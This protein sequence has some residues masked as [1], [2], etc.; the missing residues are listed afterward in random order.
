MC[1]SDL[2]LKDGN[3]VDEFAKL[4]RGGA[5][6]DSFSKGAPADLEAWLSTKGNLRSTDDDGERWD[7]RCTGPNVKGHKCETLKKSTTVDLGATNAGLM[8][9]P[10]AF[11]VILNL[12]IPTGVTGRYAAASL[13]MADGMGV[14]RLLSETLLH[15]HAQVHAYCKGCSLP[16]PS[17]I[18][19]SEWT[20]GAAKPS[21]VA[22]AAQ[23]KVASDAAPVDPNDVVLNVRLAYAACGGENTDG[24]TPDELTDLFEASGVTIPASNTS[25]LFNA[26][27][28]D[29][30]GIL[31]ISEFAV[32]YSDKVQVTAILAYSANE[33]DTSFDSKT[34]LEAGISQIGRAS[35]RERV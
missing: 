14:V 24:V 32:L 33:I 3:A 18:I 30:T 19:F 15:G 12:K 17:R 23:V 5:A 20:G 34:I 29:G 10:E 26:V 22:I 11:G 25:Y 6:P 2:E 7:L 27:D 28:F 1:S 8:C 21:G 4:T 16:V 35:C 13:V 9:D 31:D